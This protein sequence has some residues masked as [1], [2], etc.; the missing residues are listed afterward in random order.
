MSRNLLLILYSVTSCLIILGAE[1]YVFYFLTNMDTHAHKLDTSSLEE[2]SARRR[3]MPDNTQHSKQMNIRAP[4]G[5]GNRIRNNGAASNHS[6]E[7]VATR[8][9]TSGLTEEKFILV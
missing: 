8:T 7:R 5:I 3:D 6:L 2:G 4:G 1:G 9:F